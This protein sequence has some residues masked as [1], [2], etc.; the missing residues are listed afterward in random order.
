MGHET[1]PDGQTYDGEYIDGKKQ[2]K[3]KL[4]WGDGSFY[5]GNFMEGRIEGTVSKMNSLIWGIG[6]LLMD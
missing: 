4:T 1:W 3:G 2:G 6:Y 5:E